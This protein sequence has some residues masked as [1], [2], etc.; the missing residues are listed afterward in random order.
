MVKVKRPILNKAIISLL[1]TIGVIITLIVAS[2]PAQALTIS[3]T[4]PSSGYIGYW[5]TFTAQINVT[6]PDVLPV[7]S[8][9]LH[10]FSNTLT[11]L[12]TNLP[13]DAAASA[14][15]TGSGGGSAIISATAQSNW[16]YGYGSRYGYGY[17]Y[18]YGWGNFD[19]GYGYGYGYGYG[20][21]TGSTYIRY[22]VSWR[23]PVNWTPDTYNIQFLVQGNSTTTFINPVITTFTLNTYSY[24]GLE[25]N[26]PTPGTVD[27]TGK[28]DSNGKFLQTITAQSANG[29]VTLTIPKDTIG[30][31]KDGTPLT[32]ISIDPMTPPP[33]PPGGNVIGLAYDFQPDGATFA[34]PIHVTFTYNPADIPAGV[35]IED[36]VLAFY[37][38]STGTWIQLENITIDPVTH[39]ISGDISH[40]TA[41]AVVNFA[42]AAPT[43][44][45]PTTTPAVTTTSVT[46]SSTTAVVTTT[47]VTTSSTTP[48]VTTTP[49]LTSSTTPTVTTT[50]ETPLKATTN[51]GMIVGIIAGAVVLIVLVIF[52]VMRRR[53]E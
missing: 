17:G 16:G 13:L 31:N 20:D 41:Y 21:N 28:V 35:D 51:W 38:V 18:G 37:D 12:Y 10:I 48:A 47:S 52:L 33:P 42:V 5:Y 26:G 53:T 14:T 3:I 11:D 9:S 32:S 45:S 39:Q 46:T 22:R 36:L 43:T 2:S 24:T 34:P 8:V 6:D 30:T 23:S 44:T 1:V 50:P 19:F 15:Y 4:H 7:Q 29:N 27:L 49:V 25:G 40:F